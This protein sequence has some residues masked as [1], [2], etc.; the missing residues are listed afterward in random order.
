MVD[1]PL[2]SF[3]LQ[4][5][6][7][8]KDSLYGAR[9]KS[10]TG[11][12][13]MARKCGSFPSERDLTSILFFNSVTYKN[14]TFINVRFPVSTLSCSPFHP[15]ILTLVLPFPSNS[16]LHHAKVNISPAHVRGIANMYQLPATGT[17]GHA[18]SIHSH[19]V[20][21]TSLNSSAPPQTRRARTTP[22]WKTSCSR[23]SQAASMSMFHS[24]NVFLWLS[25][26]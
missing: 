25:R 1:L 7:K 19:N 13:G 2:M 5:M 12:N 22:A 15:P 8:Q 24:H 14:I 21:L 23:I 26:P 6:P 18:F 17:K 4:L 10:W 11:G 16:D 9:F 20:R 3:Q